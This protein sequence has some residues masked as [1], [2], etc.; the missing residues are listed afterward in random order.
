V[1]RLQ[2]SLCACA[3]ATAIVAAFASPAAASPETLKRSVSNILFAPLDIGL[4]PITAANAVYR[5]LNDIDDSLGVRLAYVLPGYGWNTGLFIGSGVIRLIAGVLEFVPGL[6]LVPFDT[7]M[8]P[9]FAP[10]E[11]ANSLVDI[12]TPPLN[13]KF[14]IDYSSVPY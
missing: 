7:D 12:D 14:G 3:V 8:S 4:A 11:K 5:N 2:R 9:L 13:I 10:G 1:N 6:F